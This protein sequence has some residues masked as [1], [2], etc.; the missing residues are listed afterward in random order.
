MNIHGD[1]DSI[2]AARISH[3]LRGSIDEA[4]A[5]ASTTRSEYIRTALETDHYRR[6]GVPTGATDMKAEFIERQI[7]ADLAERAA[8]T[9]ED[10]PECVACGRATLCP[11]GSAISGAVTGLLVEKARLATEGGWTASLTPPSAML[12]DLTPAIFGGAC[13]PARLASSSAATTARWSSRARVFAA[14]LMTVKGRS[15]ALRMPAGTDLTLPG[16]ERASRLLRSQKP[17]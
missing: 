5:R 1:G 4:A 15:S 3:S 9:G 13:A 10:T 6:A 14:A 2:V 11:D 17:L 12:P 7:I 8:R 16:P